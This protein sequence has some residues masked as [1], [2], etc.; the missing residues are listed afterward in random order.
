VA[1]ASDNVEASLMA[2]E[3]DMLAEQN[4]AKLLQCCRTAVR[5]WWLNSCLKFN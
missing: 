2:D 5:G 1:G 4:A 3:G